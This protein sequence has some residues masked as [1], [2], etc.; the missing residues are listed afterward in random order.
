MYD[1]IAEQI[2]RTS[3]AVEWKIQN[4]SACDPRPRT[5]KPIAEAP[6]KQAL[7]EKIFTRYWSDRDADRNKY[8]DYLQEVIKAQDTTHTAD[9][10]F[11]ESILNDVEAEEYEEKGPQKEGA[12]KTYYG[13]RY[14]RSAVN[15]QEAIRL[16]GLSCNICGFNF[17]AVYGKRGADYIEVHHIKPISTFEE[18]QHVDPKIDLTTVCSNCH[19][20]IHRRPD[21]VLS[22]EAIKLLLTATASN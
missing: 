1:Q 4:V 2:A 12:A 9:D 5:E 6:N 10:G 11:N 19:R 22:I 18:E 8:A 14:E 3:K 21:D 20:M 16:H 17:E 15:R 7:L 13:K